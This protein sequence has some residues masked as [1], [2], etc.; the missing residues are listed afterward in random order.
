[1]RFHVD[2]PTTARHT[3]QQQQNM[4]PFAVNRPSDLFD[5]FTRPVYSIMTTHASLNIVCATV[6]LSGRRTAL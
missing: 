4:K 5:S 3:G 2:D 6:V 1:M